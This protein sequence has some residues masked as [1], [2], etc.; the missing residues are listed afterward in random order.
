[1][2]SSMRKLIKDLQ[3]IGSLM[4]GWGVTIPLLHLRRIILQVKISFLKDFYNK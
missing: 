4:I 1:M 3:D 2:R